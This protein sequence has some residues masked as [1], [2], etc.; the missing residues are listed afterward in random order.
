[1]NQEKRTVENLARR[2]LMCACGIV[3]MAL[4]VALSIRAGLGISPISCVPYALNRVSDALT[5]GQYTIAMHVVFVLLQIALLRR[6][7]PPYQLL[8]LAV[9]VL[10]GVAVDGWLAVVVNL[11][12]G[13]Y[14]VR[15]A[16][17]LFSLVVVAFG[18]YLEVRADVLMVAGEGLDKAVAIVGH[19]EFGTAKVAV[20]CLLV[21]AAAAIALLGLHKIVGIREGTVAAAL[22]V[23]TLIRFFQRH[24][25]FADRF[26][27]N[28]APEK[29]GT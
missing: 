18:M 4:G 3:I 27:G 12:P 16:L 25:H 24:L 20:D 10:M 1:M 26:V 22:L 23:G 8:Q 21:A 11:Q 28:P 29:A 5:V 2:Y 13:S 15:A 7:F 14:G 9:A 19:T 17:C 6:R